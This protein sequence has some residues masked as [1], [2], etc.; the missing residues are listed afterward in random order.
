MAKEHNDYF[1]WCSNEAIAV[2]GAGGCVA[3]GMDRPWAWELLAWP[4]SGSSK[5][6]PSGQRCHAVHATAHAAAHQPMLRT[7]MW[8]N[9]ALSTLLPHP[10]CRLLPHA[11]SCP[12]CPTL[13]CAGTRCG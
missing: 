3:C 8:L 7:A 9:S 6:P 2:G 1:Q 10:F 11:A 12:C 13:P 4:H 5:L